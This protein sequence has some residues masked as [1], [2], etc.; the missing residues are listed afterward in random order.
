MEK[1][2]RRGLL[3]NAAKAAMA[4][5]GAVMISEEAM[6]LTGASTAKSSRHI[7]KRLPAGIT[8]PNPPVP[9]SNVVEFGNLLFFS[10]VG[11]H[12]PGTI[13][14][15]TKFAID[16]LEKNLI[17]AGSSLQKVLKVSVFLKNIEDYDRMNVIYKACNWGP[18][19][20]A[21]T[22]IA[23]AGIPYNPL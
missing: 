19:P 20:P 2:S 18:V 21:R 6:G 22:V 4:A 9:I 13:E 1:Q 11:D 17:A 10:S 16:A 3:K 5:T 23:P 12:A 7:E 14:E 8:P 15:H